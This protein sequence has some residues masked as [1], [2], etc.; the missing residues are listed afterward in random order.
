MT[1]LAVKYN[2]ETKSDNDNVESV[3]AAIAALTGEVE[4]KSA[5]FEELSDRL[6]KLEAKA[7]RPAGAANDNEPDAEKKAFD[8]FLRKGIMPAEQKALSVG[9]DTA[10]G[11]TVPE[12]FVNELLRNVTLFSPIR[13]YA[14]VMQITSAEAKLP[15]R[16]GTLTAAWVSETGARSASEPTYG[17]VTLTPYEA[18]VY[19][20]VS[21]Q[22]IEDSAFDLESE[23]AF[24]FGEEFGRLEGAAFVSGD[25]V[26]KPAGITTNADI[27]QINSGNAATFT[28]DSLIDLFYALKA[29]Y[30]ANAVFGM[31]ST[32]LAVARKL[33]TTDGVY[34]W[35]PA[36]AAGQPETILG[37]PVIEIPDMP[38]V[39]AGA[40]PVFFGDL[41]QGYRIADRISLSV[42]RDPYSQATN[43]LTRFHARRRVGGGVV[44][45]EAIKLMKISA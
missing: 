42:L 34:V 41:G 18:A 30:R 5:S 32:S 44:K 40:L 35:Q 10:G 20:D 15:K 38:A 2:L 27:A 16:T 4:K 3:R 33:K 37:R 29:P 1:N 31:A 11:F 8:D 25:G 36:L 22:L 13:T 12:Q 45:A 23:L 28:G 7:N 39:A 9:T 24:D 21:T 17:Q 6:A 19:T 43:G 14:R 26:G